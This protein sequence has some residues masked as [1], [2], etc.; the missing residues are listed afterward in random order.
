MKKRI[1]GFSLFLVTFV[2]V[3]L[4]HPL[5]A[6][7][8]PPN[9]FPGEPFGGS[10][11]DGYGIPTNPL[12]VANCEDLQN[13][14]LNLDRY[15]VLQ[16]NIDC[17][18]S[19]TW[20]GGKGFIPIGLNADGSVEGAFIGHL[21]G[22]GH[23]ISNLY[24]DQSSLNVADGDRNVGLFA[25]AIGADIMNVYLNNAHI[26]GSSSGGRT[27]GLAGQISGSRIDRV[28]FDGDVEGGDCSTVQSLGGITGRYIVDGPDDGA[29]NAIKYSSTKGSIT[30]TGINCGSY[31]VF[32][33]GIV[34]S[35]TDGD[36]HLL[37]NYSQMDITLDGNATED[38]VNNC[39][40]VGG[41]IGFVG[42][43]VE[44]FRNYATGILAISGDTSQYLSYQVAGLSGAN[45]TEP[46]ISQSFAATAFSFSDCGISCGAL[47]RE[48]AGIAIANI[49][50]SEA[51]LSNRYDVGVAGQG[52]GLP[53][54]SGGL[55]TC[56]GQNT[57]GVPNASLFQNNNSDW[58]MPDWDFDNV[59]ELTAQY[60]E[61]T[62]DDNANPTPPAT[63]DGS[64]YSETEITLNWSAPATYN[65]SIT[66]YFVTYKHQGAADFDGGFVLEGV[67]TG[68][69]VT[70]LEA[71][72]TY[73]FYLSAEQS[74]GYWSDMSP[75]SVRTGT[76]GF[77]GISNCQDLQ[78]INE[79]L[80]G[81]YE[82]L[83]NLDCADTSSWNSGAGF[84][85]IGSCDQTDQFQFTGIFAGNNF[86]VS[87]LYID[88][89]GSDCSL[90][91]PIAAAQGAL[92]QDV[93]FDNSTLIS[94][95][96]AAGLI[97][98]D[99]CS[100]IHNVQLTNVLISGTAELIGGLVGAEKLSRDCVQSLISVSGLLESTDFEDFQQIMGGLYGTISSSSSN[101]A[102]AVENAYTNV[103]LDASDSTMNNGVYGGIAGMIF[104]SNQDA[105]SFQDVYASGSL[106]R[107]NLETV[108]G[109][110]AGGLI[111]LFVTNSGG[112]NSL[113]DSFAYFDSSQTTNVTG[114]QV[115]DGGGLGYITAPGPSLV[116]DNTYFD[117]DV[118]GTSDCTFLDASVCTAISGDSEYFFNN[119]TNA[120][121]DQWDFSDVWMTTETLPVFSEEA[122]STPTLIPES[123]LQHN[124][125]TINPLIPARAFSPNS[126]VSPDSGK[127]TSLPAAGSNFGPTQ[128]QQPT[129]SGIIAKLKELINKIPAPLLRS[130][131]Y[132][133]VG[134][135]GLSALAMFIE[136]LRQAARLK[137]L[138]LLIQKQASVAE[139][140]DTFWHLAANYLRAPITL[141]MGGVD[142]LASP[143][144]ALSLGAGVAANAT[145][146][147]QS[148]NPE[149]TAKITKL[150]TNMQT[151]VSDIMDQIEH[152]KSLQEISWP[153][154]PNSRRL[155]ASWRF[156]LPLTMAAILLIFT[157]YVTKN[158]RHLE[159]STLSI[160]IQILLFVLVATLVYWA[161]QALGLVQNKRK[162]AEEKLSRQEAAL[163]KAR[164][165]LIGKTAEVLDDDVSKLEKMLG[166]L[167]ANEQSVPILHEGARRLRQMVDSFQLLILAQNKKL[168][169]VSSYQ[170]TVG[171]KDVLTECLDELAAEIEAKQL[172][173]LM[174]EL[175]REVVRGSEKLARQ[176]IG[177]V[178]ANAVDFSP[179]KGKLEID[180]VALHD[181]TR[182]T[183]TDHGPGV[184][185]EQQ[186]HMFQLFTKADGQDAL[187]LDHGGLGVDLY[188]DRE[189]M[190]YLGGTISID[191]GDHGTSVTITW[192]EPNAHHSDVVSPASAEA[193]LV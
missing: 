172:K 51:L 129:E 104:T 143:K 87:N 175:G 33:G 167:P 58:P 91:A 111:A 62:Q 41:I 136:M 11:M 153:K 158:Y 181:K 72:V 99:R 148:V 190:D 1:I 5:S 102:I 94:D 101:H 3:V 183:I 36:L 12:L 130:F 193:Y 147:S 18:D 187:Q 39:R 103:Q 137:E 34:G 85:P 116:V 161:V 66:H 28:H 73:E 115:I 78:A 98:S 163:D 61:L 45:S 188:L 70:N 157:N 182:L 121:L 184:S 164:I 112:E 14:N 27:G 59:W 65:G 125:G 185:K 179:K 119:S 90:A 138:N 40:S 57:S 106:V 22:R 38:C 133:V 166:Q 60:P 135:M 145:I 132:I 165:A 79:D 23:T 127:I 19:A 114:G 126:A 140:R 139:E 63:F 149:L 81:N 25:S 80:N 118:A 155:I 82:L 156:W 117:A 54:I 17:T 144:V 177:S 107:T 122:T 105:V 6:K 95:K 50:E 74:D 120:P 124:N 75:I 9:G 89:S 192:P 55:A 4:A 97:A 84:M 96:G 176:V 100:D 69:N 24:I 10:G 152:S 146:P 35:E 64:T 68:M 171:L 108:Q 92:I 141:L 134:L 162:Q 20:N 159:V 174:P 109:S 142:L 173:V 131:P 2:V 186:A 67:T 113:T 21:D 154:S 13:V 26:I 32:A 151:K 29:Y 150:V 8:Y 160:L 16:Q 77:I 83:Q 49:D 53:C 178:L 31:E 15:Y 180:F 191:T 52:D 168:Q 46:L 56:E 93:T 110:L 7:A 48:V 88:V 169:K 43:H 170:A 76:E 42:Q 30:V 189:I 44:I 71:G 37:N 47:P 86:T 128:G 123:R